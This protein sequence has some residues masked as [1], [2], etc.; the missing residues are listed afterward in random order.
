MT[1]ESIAAVV[2]DIRAGRIRTPAE[3]GGEPDHA[4][5]LAEVCTL[6]AREG[7]IV[8]AT[9]LYRNMVDRNEAIAMYEDH[10]DI[11]PP[12]ELAVVA[13]ENRHGNVLCVCVAADGPERWDTA[14]TVEWERVRWRI[15]ALVVIGGRGARGPIPTS[16][17]MHMWEIAV[18]DDGEPADLHWLQLCPSIDT[19]GWAP[20]RI[21][22]ASSVR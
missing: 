11:A 5:K 18:Y 7:P 6:A 12:F 16:G 19:G 20:D 13:H 1:A 15:S 2:A 9:A 4:A 14:N 3:F 22:A 10:P 17:P 8:D 21:R